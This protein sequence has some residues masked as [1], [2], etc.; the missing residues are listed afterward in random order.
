MTRH[1]GKAAAVTPISTRFLVRAALYAALYAALTLMPGL[2]A[3][4]YGAVQFRVAESLLPFACIDP[5]AVVGLT[6]GTALGNLG[7][8]MFFVDVVFGALLTL[9]AA[10]L[11]YRI[12][13]HWY[14][15]AVPVVVN[16]L[17]VAAMLAVV[18]DLPF[19]ASALWVSAGEAAV[20]A[21]G[22]AVVLLLVRRRSDLFG[23]TRPDA[24]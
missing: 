24:G 17:G 4:A 20:M 15:L 9:V 18:M 1:P 16:G 2:N 8:P 5:A 22:G 19:W 13:P 11:M 14:A 21:T 3:L 6:L 23:T 10:A 7:S 12:G